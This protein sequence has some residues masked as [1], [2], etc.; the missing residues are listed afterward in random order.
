[1]FSLALVVSLVLI[2]LVG[3]R[4]LGCSWARRWRHLPLALL[5]APLISLGLGAWT[6]A[7]VSRRV[8]WIG[9]PSWGYLIGLAIPLGM[10]LVALGALALAL[11]RLCALWRFTRRRSLPVPPALRATLLGIAPRL[12]VAPPALLLIPS[13]RPRALVC[14]WPGGRPRLLLSTWL[15]ARLDAWETEGVLAHEVAHIARRDHLVAWLALLLR[16]AFCY[17]PSS[18]AAFRRLQQQQELA[19]DDLAVAATGRPLALAS[20]LAKVW[21]ATLDERL[22]FT[23]TVG[24]TGGSADIEGRIRRLMDG[25]RQTSASPTR[26]PGALVGAGGTAAAVFG[27]QGANLALLLVP[28]GC[29]SLLRMLG[30]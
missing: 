6:L 26:G 14:G 11:L 15:P 25:T 3:E 21:Q 12:D 5:A 1:M 17:L 24:L 13:R 20:A 10:G 19:C 16:D 30:W 7:Q 18:W 9:I 27:L 22:G 29:G 8:C 28:V 4:A 2:A 23:T